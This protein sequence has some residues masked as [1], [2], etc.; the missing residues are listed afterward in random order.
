MSTNAPKEEVEIKRLYF[1]WFQIHR[2]KCPTKAEKLLT[3]LMYPIKEI[4]PQI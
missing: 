2:D 4:R 1:E 3:Y